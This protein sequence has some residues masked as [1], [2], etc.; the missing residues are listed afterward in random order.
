MGSV[1][2]AATRR[3]DGHVNVNRPILREA[4]NVNVVA[5]GVDEDGTVRI[6]VLRQPR[7]AADDPSRPGLDGHP[8]VVFGQIVMGF[9]EE[10]SDADGS[11]RLET[12]VEGAVREVAEE[13]GAIRVIEVAMPECPEHNPNPSFVASWSRIVFVK[14]DLG[15]RESPGSVPVAGDSF[16]EEVIDAVEFLSVPE[17]LR[18][19]RDGRDATGAVYRSGVSN[20]VLMVFFACYPEFFVP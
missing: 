17:L 11:R 13:A 14:V 7:P 19:I 15:R 12:S 10:T 16:R 2:S 1:C 6:A 8:P 4:P 3:S 9:L 5:W 20:A 18:R